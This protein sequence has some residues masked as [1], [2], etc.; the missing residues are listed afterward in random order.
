MPPQTANSKLIVHRNPSSSLSEAYRALRM[1][2]QFASGE[3][4]VKTIMVTSPGNGDGKSTTIANLAV[5]Y[6]QEGKKTLLIDGDIRDPSL[7]HLF[8]LSNVSGLTNALLNEKGWKS[9]IQA[10]QIPRLS[11]MTSGITPLHPS[12]L[13]ASEYLP[14]LISDIKQ[15][16]DIVLFDSPPLLTVTDGLKI[17]SLCDGVFIVASQGKTKKALLKKVRQSLEHANARV[18]GVVLNKT[19]YSKIL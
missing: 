19:K 1:N 15:H 13:L 9:V 4:P 12:D 8:S 16:F 2:I 3:D 6:A 17:C 14:D 10:T 18:L 5:A 11:V 7:H